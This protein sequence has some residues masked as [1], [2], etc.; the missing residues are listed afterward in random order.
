MTTVEGHPKSEQYGGTGGQPFQ[1]DL[2]E[3]KE[4]IA[5]SIRH[6]DRIDAILGVWKTENGEQ[7][8][9]K[10]HGG[11]GGD[12]SIIVLE[13]NEKINKVLIRYGSLVDSLEFHTSQNRQF[14]PFGGAG[15]EKNVEVPGNILGFFGRAGDELNAIGFFFE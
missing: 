7:I 2:P 3:A 9:G 13:P 10:Q 15:G 8:T 1:D 5:I 4:L 12:E 14:G 11:Y 6:G